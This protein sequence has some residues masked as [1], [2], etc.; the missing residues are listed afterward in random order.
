MIN[1]ETILE[2]EIKS[3]LGHKPTDKEIASCKEYI[4]EHIDGDTD[5]TKLANLVVDWKDDNC[6][7]CEMCGDWGLPD[8]MCTF[9]HR[10][11]DKKF[12]NMSCVNDYCRDCGCCYDL[13]AGCL[14][15][16]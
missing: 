9:Y 10:M 13:D 8:E 2:K 14:L 3:W 7:Q 16:M 11:T 6:V 1:Y 12:C 4:E 5:F 15:D